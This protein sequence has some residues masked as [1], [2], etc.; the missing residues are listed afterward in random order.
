M[1]TVTLDRPERKNP[2]TFEAYRELADT[3]DRL[4][5]VEEVRAVVLTGAGGNFCSG[6]DVHEIIGP[7]VELRAAGR[8]DRLLAFTRL[9]GE[10]VRTMR[11]CPQPIVAAV[12]GTCVGAGAILAM[13]SDL[14]L[15]TARS[16]VAFLFVK[17]GLSGADMGACALLPRIVGQGRA[18]EL[19]Y[20]GR[21][22]AGEEAERWGFYNRLVEPERLLAE[23]QEL[24][25]GAR[26]RADL[27]PRDDQAELAPGVGDGG[28]RGDR[29]GGA[30]AGDLHA[31]GGL[32]AGLPGVCG[33]GEAGVR[34][35]L[36]ACDGEAESASTRVAPAGGLPAPSRPRRLGGAEPGYGAVSHRLP[37]AVAGGS[38]S[39]PAVHAP[40]P[41]P[42]PIFAR[43]QTRVLEAYSPRCWEGLSD[44]GVGLMADRSFFGWPFFDDG[45]RVLARELEAWAEREI[46]PLVEE[47]GELDETCRELVRRLAVGGWLA[48]AVPGAWSDGAGAGG[49]AREG[50]DVRS[51]CLI[52]ETLARYGGLADFVFAMQG[53]GSGPISLFGSEE[54]KAT[55]LPRVARGEA[56]A[57]FALSEAGAG[58]DVAAMTTRA[59][60]DG[61]PG[62]G[63]GSSTARRPGSRTPGSLISTSSSAGCRRGARRPLAP[64]SSRQGIPGWRSRRASTCWPRIRSAP[65][66][67]PA[68]GCRSRRWWARRG[69]G[70]RSPTAPSTSFAPPSAP[71]RWA[72]PA[73]PSTRRRRYVRARHAFGRPLADYQLTQARLADMA[74][75][76]DAAALLVYRAAWTRDGGAPRITREAAMAKLYATEAAQRVVDDALQLFGGRGLVAGAPVERLYREVRALR[77]YEGTSE[78][79]RLIIAGRV[80]AD[81]GD[82]VESADE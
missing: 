12:D 13:A 71:P 70:W 74:T 26:R 73:A 7:L 69:A 67:W 37:K 10:L 39:A 65:C 24:A 55:W 38:P 61:S 33:E 48:H 54:L 60:R 25:A 16:R 1:A 31:D 58:S 28:G 6:G 53:L 63:A 81:A 72:S 79:Q 68:A 47:E 43:R 34:G 32:R 49:G 27:R 9:T 76:I 75:A 44:G 51:L 8:M 64:S 46:A 57:A 19:L 18:S 35:G 4:R 82:S 36:A 78:I 59:V 14:R 66:V 11:A 30:G 56:I 41:P 15:G 29:G 2:L 77:V 52:R 20:T 42:A 5:R 40:E 21:F 17:V 50:L 45:H 62:D 22:M 3:F 80:L 23:A